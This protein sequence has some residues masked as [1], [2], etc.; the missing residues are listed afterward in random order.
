MLEPGI[1]RGLIMRFP[2]V[3]AVLSA[4]SMVVP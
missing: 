2:K 1:Q 4:K 3:I